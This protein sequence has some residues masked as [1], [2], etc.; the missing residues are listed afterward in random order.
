MVNETDAARQATYWPVESVSISNG[1]VIRR[2]G[3]GEERVQY[4]RSAAHLMKS[5]HSGG[6]RGCRIPA[7]C[8]DGG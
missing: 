2:R 4:L 8:A 3:V 5:S 7:S 6:C 1:W